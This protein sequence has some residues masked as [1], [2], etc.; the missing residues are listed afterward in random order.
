MHVFD[1]IPKM[2]IF[3]TKRNIPKGKTTRGGS[4][5]CSSD[6]VLH[7]NPTSHEAG[8]KLEASKPSIFGEAVCGLAYCDSRLFGA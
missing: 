8:C 2:A 1:P 7:S 5:I 3:E 4:F 6:R